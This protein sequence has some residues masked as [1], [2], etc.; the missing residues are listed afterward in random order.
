MVNTKAPST[1]A[2]VRF[3]KLAEK[4]IAGSGF[5][6]ALLTVAVTPSTVLLNASGRVATPVLGL[7][8]SGTSSVWPANNI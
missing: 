4:M 7:T 2:P 8:T 3:V 5:N 1:G 6:V